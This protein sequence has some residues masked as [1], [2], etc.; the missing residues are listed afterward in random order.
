MQSQRESQRKPYTVSFFGSIALALAVLMYLYA[1][2]FKPENVEA[3][4]TMLLLLIVG[5]VLSTA[6]VGV[7]FIPFNFKSLGEDIVATGI[8]A[9][10]I[11]ILNN[12]VKAEIGISPIGET[13]FGILAGVSEEWFFRLWL[14]AWIYKI[15]KSATIAILISSGAWS[16]F[17]IARYGANP[18]MLILVFLVGIPLGA[19]T[20]YMRSA[21]GSTFGHGMVN[22]IAR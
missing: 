18:A 11:F 2:T 20:I 4:Y 13:A 7:R 6:M 9:G 14:C 22:A 15:T 1:T 5:V 10:S 16:I 3:F 8:S 21:D 19:V 12:T 17:H